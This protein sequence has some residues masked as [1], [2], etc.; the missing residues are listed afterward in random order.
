MLD[1]DS[2]IPA[3]F[4]CAFW[5]VSSP[6]IATK[7]PDFVCVC[8]KFLSFA[9]PYD[10]SKLAQLAWQGEILLMKKGKK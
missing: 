2:T 1:A 9:C 4:T 8:D 7:V 3:G 5:P 10:G 6:L